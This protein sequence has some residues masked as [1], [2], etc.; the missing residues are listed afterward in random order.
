MVPVITATVTAAYIGRIFFGPHPSF[1]IPALDTPY[2][3]VAKPVLLAAY[4]GLG[5]ITGLVSA[6]FIWSLYKCEEFFEKHVRGG[7]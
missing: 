5:A 7:Y 2:F 6:L 4:G 1:Y 3:A